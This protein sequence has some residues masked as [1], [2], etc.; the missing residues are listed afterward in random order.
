M[1][2]QS[3]RWMRA[4]RGGTSAKPSLH[5]LDKP[6]IFFNRTAAN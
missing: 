6:E 5:Y 2:R 4:L 3:Q 1:K